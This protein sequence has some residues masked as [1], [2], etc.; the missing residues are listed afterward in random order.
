MY[1]MKLN[2]EV[3]IRNANSVSGNQLHDLKTIYQSR[4]RECTPSGDGPDVQRAQLIL[5]AFFIL[6]WHTQRFDFQLC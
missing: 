3:K 5:S 4:G 6:Q 1:K 2:F